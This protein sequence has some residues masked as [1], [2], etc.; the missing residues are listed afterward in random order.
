MCLLNSVLC[1]SENKKSA[2]GCVAW[3]Q[4]KIR[5]AMVRKHERNGRN[6]HLVGVVESQRCTRLGFSRGNLKRPAPGEERAGHGKALAWVEG[7]TDET[8][9]DEGSRPRPGEEESVT[10]F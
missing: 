8:T 5:G 2:K 6:A 9:A 7:N 1:E 3:A 4:N 10:R